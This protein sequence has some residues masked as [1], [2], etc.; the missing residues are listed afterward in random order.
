MKDFLTPLA[1]LLLG[2]GLWL[3]PLADSPTLPDWINP[4]NWIVK[5]PA[6]VVIIEETSDRMKLPASQLSI[7]VSTSLKEGV[8][9]N[10]GI[11]IGC[12][13]KDIVDRDKKT[14]HEL[15]PYLEAAKNVGTPALVYKR[16]SKYKAIPLPVTE[17]AAIE[18]IL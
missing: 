10:G 14:P 15:L 17:K 9:A 7:L 3:N 13:D 5:G 16:G 12:F 8:E 2:I 11:F 4:A 1:I 6:T 18:A